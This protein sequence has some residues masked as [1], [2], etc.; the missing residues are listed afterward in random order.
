MFC[1]RGRAWSGR[2]NAVS[3]ASAMPP[4]GRP[5]KPV[6]PRRLKKVRR[7]GAPRR[8]R[9][10]A[11]SGAARRGPGD[12]RS[13]IPRDRAEKLLR[14]KAADYGD[15]GR[16]SGATLLPDSPKRRSS[17][18]DLRSAFAPLV[19]SRAANPRTPCSPI[20]RRAHVR[21]RLRHH[22]RVDLRRLHALVAGQFL[23]DESGLPAGKMI[24]ARSPAVGKVCT[25]AR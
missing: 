20:Q 10:C 8:L 5:L 22:M 15:G 16:V 1:F 19:R 2:A 18:A 4:H 3:S 9:T 25:D 24:S 7:A 6:R 23:A 12:P 21:R 17:P 11:Q 13:E 14:G